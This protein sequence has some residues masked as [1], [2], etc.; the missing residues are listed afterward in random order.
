MISRSTLWAVTVVAAIAAA[1]S[2][3]KMSPQSEAQAVAAQPSIHNILLEVED[4]ERSLAFYRDRLGLT[5][6][7]KSK[8]FV[9]LDSE[10][11]GVY[12]WSSR[13]D[14]EEKPRENERAG[15][16]M[17]PHFAVEDARATVEALR[18]AGETVVQ[19]PRS[20]NF[21]VE[22]FVADPDGY[23]WAL[24]SPPEKN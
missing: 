3:G 6:K 17:Y 1:Y 4:L 2:F 8:D 11:V 14:W 12:L 15:L 20:Y 24:I 19:E 16:G 13:W 7:S 10:N 21:G 22:A 18:A 23:T 9:T 5:L